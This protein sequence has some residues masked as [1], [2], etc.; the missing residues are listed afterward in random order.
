MAD[1]QIVQRGNEWVAEIADRGRAV[2]H[3][4]GI[5]RG[6]AFTYE[7]RQE[8]GLTGLLPPEVLDIE[9]QMRRVYT[10]LVAQST[11]LAKYVFL[12][13]LLDRNQVLFYRVLHDHLDELLP[14]YTGATI[15][16]AVRQYSQ[17][18]LRPRGVFLDIDHPA[19]IEASLLAYGRSADDVDLI[20]V[21]D[22]ESVMAL[23]DQ[24]VG[25]VIVA[26]SKSVL[27]TTA[28]GIHPLRILPV[29]ID[30]GTDNQDL[31]NEPGYLG[32]HHERVRGPAYEAFIAAFVKS[33]NRVFPNAMIHWEDFEDAN[34]H[35]IFYGYRDV[36]LSYND[37]IQG[38][39]SVA[40]A[41]VLSGLKVSGES[42]ADQRIVIMGAD[43]AGVGVANLLIRVMV[44]QG[45]SEEEA[46]SHF[47]IIDSNG[48]LLQRGTKMW[49]FQDP[50]ARDPAEADTWTLNRPGH[51]GLGDVVRYI[52]PTVLI[53][54]GSNQAGVI[55]R[56]IVEHMSATTAHPIILPLSQPTS[57]AEADVADIIRWSG[58]R[59][60]T[61]APGVHE[62]VEFEGVKHDI[63]QTNNVLIFPGIG[64]GAMSCHPTRITRTATVVAAQALSDV[65]T[66]HSVGSPLL[67]N[68]SRVREIAVRIAEAV[69]RQACAEG[70]AQVPLDEALAA[71]G[72]HVWFPDY[73]ELELT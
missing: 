60:L 69:V 7:Q 68:L 25:G 29:V 40:T 26:V 22:S 10:Q 23:G 20:V 27:Y 9:A 8:L 45:I 53:G 4:R 48:G 15:G 21:T 30:N 71:I 66:D 58:G 31:L 1:Y 37:D 38:T 14:I 70:S 16:D 50:F 51:V 28:A 47:W 55:T 59:A 17:W 63:A 39:A 56:E 46:K 35:R 3:T 64:L 43:S 13:N 32:L 52:H 12:N 73:P 42:L 11:D 65:L 44:N 41:A 5:N 24:G 54:H 61:A 2:L 36:T 67:P 18:F 72:E 33:V 57:L 6:T 62:P 19:D 49:K 34:A